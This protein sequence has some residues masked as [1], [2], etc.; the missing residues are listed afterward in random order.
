MI[1]RLMLKAMMQKNDG[2]AGGSEMSFW[3][4]LDALRGTLWRCVV[5]LLLTTL[6]MAAVMP[7]LFDRIIMWPCR[8]DFFLYGAIDRFASYWG[9]APEVMTEPVRLVNIELASQ[10]FIHMSASLWLGLVTALPGM[11]FFVW[12]FVAPALYDSERR[13]LRRAF[14][15]AAVMFYA[16]V[17]VGY[18]VV[19]PLTLR[20]LSGYQLS[21]L[22]PNTISLTSYVDTFGMLTL[23][24]GL[25]FELPVLAWL[26]G[27]MGVLTRDMFSRYRRHAVVALLVLSAVITPTTDPFTLMVVF[28]PVYLLWEGAAILVPRRK[29]ESTVAVNIS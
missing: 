14:A 10:L 11:L 4:H 26:L 5:L 9:V 13:G 3:D 19:F 20:F 23:L 16:G 6:V 15:G 28:I 24:M 25:L 21:A 27:R 17:A 18:A 22:V 29:A 12:Q 2:G 1:R 8:P 7:A